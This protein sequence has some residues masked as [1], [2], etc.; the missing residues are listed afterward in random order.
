MFLK[1]IIETWTNPV[2]FI[3]GIEISKN[4]K[5]KIVEAGRF[6]PSAGNQQ[7]FRFLLIDNE[8]SNK[9]I[10]QSIEARDPRLASTLKQIKKPN[11]RNNFVYSIENFNAKTDKYKVYIYEHHFDDINCAKSA[12]FFIICTHKNTITGKMFGHTDMGAAI[13]NMI[14]MAYDLGYHCRWIRIFDREFIRERFNIPLSIFI[15]AIL[16]VGKV[17]ENVEITEYKAKDVNDFYFYNQW[18]ENL[19]I[20]DWQSENI[21]FN[22]YD[23]EVVDAIVDRRSIRSF[24]ENKSIPR[25]IIL[26][27]LKAGMII[28]LTI[29]HP[30]L[31]IIVVEDRSFLNQIAKHSK[32]VLKQSHVGEVPLIIVITYD[33]SNNSPGFYSETDSGSIIQS[34][35]LRAHTLGIGSCWIGAFNR[36]VVRK[37]LKIPEDWHIPSMAIFGYPNNYPKPTPRVDLGKVCYYNSWKNHIKKRKRTLL[38]DYFA[39]SIWFRK[40]RNTQVTTLLRKRKVGIVKGIPEFEQFL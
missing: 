36:K 25:S 12:S 21:E 27:L 39:L 40:F 22:N 23:I 14:L 5:L 19:T 32:I 28:P 20:K 26:E 3:E 6:A 38:P 34:I 37:I 24:N 35:L 30:Y 31:K 1:E 11:L 13:T 17:K 18:D 10:I 4:D 9:I 15:D 33:C 7:V 29:N 8:N 2:Q 16:V